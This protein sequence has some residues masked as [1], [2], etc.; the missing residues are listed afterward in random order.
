MK[1]FCG[2]CGSYDEF[3]ECSCEDVEDNNLT[4]GAVE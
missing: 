3:S 1:S 2:V 4:E